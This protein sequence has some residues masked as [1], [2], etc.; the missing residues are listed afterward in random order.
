MSGHDR[1]NGIR[2]GLSLQER[3]ERHEF[4]ILQLLFGLF[5]DRQGEMGIN[6]RVA[7]SRKVF[8]TRRDSSTSK[9]SRR[10]LCVVC[11]LCSTV[12]KTSDTCLNSRLCH[13]ESQS[14]SPITGF[15][16]SQLTSA[17]GE[18]AQLNPSSFNSFP[19]AS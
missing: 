16:H 6:T 12:S 1:C 18:Y 19:V 4:P 10:G 17:T 2:V 11:Y 8:S 9:P 13:E 5:D 14:D 3:F 7:M 15:F